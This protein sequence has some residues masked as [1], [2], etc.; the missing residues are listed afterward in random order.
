VPALFGGAAQQGA[1]NLAQLGE[2]ERAELE[3]LMS[4]LVA[5]GT[6]SLQTIYDRDFVPGG[7]R[8][9]ATAVE[10][11]SWTNPASWLR[12]SDGA[13]RW[14]LIMPA[15]NMLLRLGMTRES[16]PVGEQITVVL[17]A[18]ASGQPLEDGT[19]LGRVE[20]IVRASDGT[21]VFDRAAMPAPQP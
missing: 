6:E 17:T 7:T 19:Q 20:S 13:T 11:M 3:R 9:V 10:G 21:V 12:I 15:P 16:L 2:L 18:D 14:N 1:A 5:A 8:S 4:E